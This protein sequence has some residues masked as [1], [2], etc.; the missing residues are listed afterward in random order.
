MASGMS[1]FRV[2]RTGLPLSQLSATAIFSRFCSIRSAILL[3]M[4]A[5]SAG[6]VLPQPRCGVVGGVQRELDVLGGGPGDLGEDLAVHRRHVLEVLALDRCDPLATDPVVVAG[7]VADHTA[8][9]SW[10]NVNRHSRPPRR[11]VRP[12]NEPH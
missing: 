1:A 4:T 12:P 11:C 7:F 6:E 10:W 2:S 3:R 8:R 5:R 9:L